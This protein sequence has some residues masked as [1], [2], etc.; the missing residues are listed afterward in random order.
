MSKFLHQHFD[1]ATGALTREE[2]LDHPFPVFYPDAESVQVIAIDEKPDI[3]WDSPRIRDQ[4]T[5]FLHKFYDAI[6]NGSSSVAIVETALQIIAMTVSD[7]PLT[8]RR[9]IAI[10]ETEARLRTL[11]AEA[12]TAPDKATRNDGGIGG[13]TDLT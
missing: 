1:K 4:V 5:D 8:I 2:V 13:E 3:A 6:P 7:I 9:E 11:L 10:P 12:A